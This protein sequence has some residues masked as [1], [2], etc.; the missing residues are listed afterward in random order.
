MV[1]LFRRYSW[2]AL[3]FCSIF[4]LSL[5]IFRISDYYQ[6]AHTLSGQAVSAL[7]DNSIHFSLDTYDSLDYSFLQELSGNFALIEPV[8][9]GLPLYRVVYSRDYFQ[10]S[11]GRSFTDTDFSK[12]DRQ[13]LLADEPTGALDFENAQNIMNLLSAL[14]RTKGTTIVLVTH[15]K[16]IA[17]QC[18]QTVL[19]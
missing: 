16:E 8:E 12:G 5:F 6:S 17:D 10:V 18:H 15:D 9:S 13:I 19:L 4:L 7:R 11:E 14:N 3:L 1:P 2:N